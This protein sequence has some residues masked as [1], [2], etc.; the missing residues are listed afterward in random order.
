MSKKGVVE[1]VNN[2]LVVVTGATGFV[3]RCLVQKL[4]SSGFKVLALVRDVER[5]RKTLNASPGADVNFSQFDL[6]DKTIKCDMK[7]ALAVVH[8]GAYIPK[9]YSNSSEA[10][11]CWTTNSWGT[12]RLIEKAIDDD[13]PYFVYLSTGNAYADRQQQARESDPLYP[14]ANAP[15]YLTSKI[16]GEVFVD[17]LRQRGLIKTAILRPSAIYGPGMPTEALVARMIHQINC[18]QRLQV[19]DG[20]R[21]RVDL[22]YVRDVVQAI[23]GCLELQAQGI[24]NV[25]SGIST[26]TL[27]LAQ[28][29]L[30]VSGLDLTN[31]DMTGSSDGPQLGFSALDITRAREHLRYCPTDLHAGLL[32]MLKDVAI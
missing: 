7:N 9:S 1:S 24:F 11:E 28:E 20:G 2:S 25:G 6:I 32:A 14:S 8:S 21:Y 10:L 18:R 12:H 29:V 22:V 4:S 30:T 16:N 13:V 27:E 23:M 31:I 17:H 26:S 15:Y 19:H 5:A 3:G